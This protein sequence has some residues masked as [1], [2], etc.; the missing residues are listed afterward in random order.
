MINNLKTIDHVIAKLQS[1]LY[2]Q[3]NINEDEVIEWISDAYKMI[4]SA[5]QFV[6]KRYVL[7]AEDF[8]A[9]FPC[10]FYSLIEVNSCYNFR[11]FDP[12]SLPYENILGF[13]LAKPYSFNEVMNVYNNLRTDSILGEYS[14]FHTGYKYKIKHNYIYPGFRCGLIELKYNALP[15]DP[16]TGYLLVPD[17]EAFDTAFMWY[18]G[19]WLAARGQVKNFSFNDCESRWL[20]YCNQARASANFPDN[21]VQDKIGLK[22]NKQ[23]MYIPN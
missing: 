23:P 12:T 17:D 1:K 13:I 16:E 10:D 20:K 22:Y 5:E 11:L 9:K 14:Y 19:M 2:I 21:L 3:D 4:G 7:Y 6:E 15:T 18:V 8:K